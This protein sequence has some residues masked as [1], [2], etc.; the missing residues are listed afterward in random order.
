MSAPRKPIEATIDT[1][2]GAISML[3]DWLGG[4]DPKQELARVEPERNARIPAVVVDTEGED[5]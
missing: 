4:P 2:T 1:V 5:A 3:Y